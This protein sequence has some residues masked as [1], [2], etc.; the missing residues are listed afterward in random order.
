MAQLPDA[1]D[2]ADVG[3]AKGRH[4]EVERYYS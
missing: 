1:G 3:E 2:A 4:L